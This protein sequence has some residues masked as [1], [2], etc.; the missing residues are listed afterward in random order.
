MIVRFVNQQTKYPVAPWRELLVRI[1]PAALDATFLGRQLQRRGLD[2]GLTVTFAGPRVMRRINAATR[3]IDQITDVLSFPLLE[4]F[5][6][7]LKQMPGIQDIDPDQ[8]DHSTVLIG[9]III[10]L[11]KAFSQAA[12]F[13]HPVEREVA[14]LAVHGVLHLAGFDHDTRPREKKMLQLQQ[15][16][17]DQM[18]LGRGDRK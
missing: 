15:Q 2:A 8:P 14:F 12:D 3:Q 9:D 11:D 1:L 4:A 13:G 6:G 10:S 7:H 17:L 16:V 5:D 18:G